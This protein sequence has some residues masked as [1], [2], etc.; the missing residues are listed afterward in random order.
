MKQYT[1]FYTATLAAPY[2][3]TIGCSKQITKRDDETLAKALERE[4]IDSGGVIGI[5]AGHHLLEE[6]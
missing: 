1:V 3:P 2:S 5:I 4:N 6:F